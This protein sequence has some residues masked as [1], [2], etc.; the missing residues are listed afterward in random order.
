MASGKAVDTCPYPCASSPCPS[1]GLCADISSAAVLMTLDRSR[2]IKTSSEAGM[3]GIEVLDNER[4]SK[5][6]SARQFQPG[7]Y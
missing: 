2:W 1:F 5:D 6:E 4:R 7:F 3:A